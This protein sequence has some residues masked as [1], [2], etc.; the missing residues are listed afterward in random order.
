[1]DRIDL[2]LI[3]SEYIGNNTIFS[4]QNKATKP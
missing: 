1:M 3:T 4:E 2:Q